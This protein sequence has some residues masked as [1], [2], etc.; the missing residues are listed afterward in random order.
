MSEETIDLSE[1]SDYMDPAVFD[2]PAD[3]ID[4]IFVQRPGMCG[5]GQSCIMRT[6]DWDTERRVWPSGDGFMI[7]IDDLEIGGK[8][9][10]PFLTVDECMNAYIAWKL[11]EKL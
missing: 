7:S 3:Q 11:Q 5:G 9:I 6:L 8:S 2:C 4:E 10:G 1:F